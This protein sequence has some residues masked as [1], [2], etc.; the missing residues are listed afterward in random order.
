MAAELN[1]FYARFNGENTDVPS[2]VSIVPNG[3][4]ILVAEADVRDPS[5]GSGRDGVTGRFLKTHLNQ[6]AGGFP[7][8]FNF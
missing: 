5:G 6:L 7:A 2:R 1:V 3:I 4:V 8:I